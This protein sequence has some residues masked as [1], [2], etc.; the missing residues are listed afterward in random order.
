[1]D[2]NND[3]M[4]YLHITRE[5]LKDDYN[6]II[7]TE[8]LFNNQPS[9]GTTNAEN[10]KTLKGLYRKETRLHL[11]VVRLSDYLTETNTKGVKDR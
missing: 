9:Q 2:G 4:S 11:H 7:L 6:R 3:A 10:R 8:T 5:L 1:M